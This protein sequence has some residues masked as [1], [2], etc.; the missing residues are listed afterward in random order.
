MNNDILNPISKEKPC[1]DNIRHTEEFDALKQLRKEE[2]HSVSYDIWARPL[3][4]ANWDALKEK[5]GK[6]LQTKS[7]D[8][9]I[10]V[11][12]TEC[13]SNNFENLL[14]ALTLV[15]KFVKKFFGAFHPLDESTRISLFEWIERVYVDRILRVSLRGDQALTLDIWRHTLFPKEQNIDKLRKK[16]NF[17]SD[18][19]IETMKE[20]V[21]DCFEEIQ[22]IKM[23]LNTRI[24]EAPTFQ[25]FIGCL[26]ELVG[27]FEYRLEHKEKVTLETSPVDS[28]SLG[29]RDDGVSMPGIEEEYE[30]AEEDLDQEKTL[31]RKIDDLEELLARKQ[32]ML[33]SEQVRLAGQIIKQQGKGRS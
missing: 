21:E 16:L 28:I 13:F 31:L 20:L 6:I 7:K 19:E 12:Y 3:K 15:N 11:W 24:K 1:G 14:S 22:D 23:F 29:E 32:Y 25:E 30:S 27:I 10:L 4:S 17:V 33:A 2:D 26:N 5:T 18:K 9:Q 8:L